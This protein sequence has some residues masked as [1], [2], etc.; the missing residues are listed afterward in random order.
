MNAAGLSWHVLAFL[1]V[2]ALVLEQVAWLWNRKLERQRARK[3]VVN[4][5]GRAHES[6]LIDAPLLHALDSVFVK[7]QASNGALREVLEECMRGR[8]SVTSEHAFTRGRRFQTSA[9]LAALLLGGLARAEEAPASDQVSGGVGLAAQSKA[10][11][12]PVLIIGV[13]FPIYFGSDN[14]DA[15]ARGYSETSVDGLEGETVDFGNAATFTSVRGDLWLERRVGSDG[16]GGST[17]LALH[18][19]GAAR[20]DTGGNEPLTRAPVWYS[21]D[22]VLERRSGDHFPNRRLTIG[23][24]HSDLSSPPERVSGSLREAARNASPR[25]IMVGGNVTVT[26][27]KAADGGTSMKVVIGGYVH[28]ALWGKHGTFAA[29]VTTTVTFGKAS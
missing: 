29:L 6:G 4:V 16:N 24:G 12:V 23:F 15:T 2:V 18:G 9:L 25:D 22:L 11:A 5:L 8:K 19:G 20:L 10:K 21:G 3:M 14:V 17:Y 27:M 1:L 28:R 26:A 7:Y 13:D